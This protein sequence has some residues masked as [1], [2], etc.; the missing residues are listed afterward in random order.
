MN[1]NSISYLL[2]PKLQLFFY[3]LMK[4]ISIQWWLKHK[5]THVNIWCFWVMTRIKAYLENGRKNTNSLIRP[6]NSSRRKWY[7]SIG[8]TILSQNSCDIENG[9]AGKSIN[10]K[11]QLVLGMILSVLK[12]LLIKGTDL[13]GHYC[14]SVWRRFQPL[15]GTAARDWQFHH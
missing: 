6:R 13:F 14:L 9:I 4:L 7:L 10:Y 5:V 8:W 1:S 3:K 11:L 12:M 15:C 2:G